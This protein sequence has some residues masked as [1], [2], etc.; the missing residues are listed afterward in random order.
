MHHVSRQT[1]LYKAMLCPS[2]STAM[3]ANDE[4]DWFG[5]G[6]AK[7]D[8]S[9]EGFQARQHPTQLSSDAHARGAFVRLPPR[10]LERN[11]VAETAMIVT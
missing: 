9:R 3:D 11:I 1:L 7:P 8:L 6:R 2:C 10:G 5:P 4:W